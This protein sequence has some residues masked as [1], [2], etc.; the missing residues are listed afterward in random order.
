LQLARISVPE[1]D[2]ADLASLLHGAGFVELADR[3]ER[4]LEIEI[5]ILALA[6]ESAR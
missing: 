2:V 3:F 5:V 6:I 1:S 4:A